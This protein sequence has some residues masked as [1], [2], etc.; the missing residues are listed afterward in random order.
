MTPHPIA[1]ELRLAPVTGVT[2]FGPGAYVIDMGQ[3]TQTVAI[4]LRPYMKQ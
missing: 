3:A 2:S 4:S 1:L